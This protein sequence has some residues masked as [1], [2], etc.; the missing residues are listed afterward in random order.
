M[1]IIAD[2]IKIKDSKAL[3]ILIKNDNDKVQTLILENSEV[4]NVTFESGKGKIILKE[5][6]LNGKIIGTK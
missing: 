6:K 1:E 5:S 3:D 4:E 2:V